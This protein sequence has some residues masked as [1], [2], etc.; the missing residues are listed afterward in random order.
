[1]DPIVIVGGAVAASAAGVGLRV[2]ARLIPIGLRARRDLREW[3]KSPEAQMQRRFA[4]LEK[5][6]RGLAN[7]KGRKRDSSIVGIYEDALRHV[8]GSYTRVYDVTL[9]ETMLSD[10]SVSDRRHDELARMFC[11]P[12]PPGTVMQYRYAV[13]PD[14]GRAIAEHLRT[15]NYGRTHMPASR[16]HDMNVDFYKALADANL[17]RREQA[18][19]SIRAPVKQACDETSKGLSAFTPEVVREIRRRGLTNFADAVSSSWARTADDGVVRR[20]VEDEQEA[21]EQAEK[22]FRTTEMQSPVSLR[23]L[24]R[25]QLWEVIYKGHV[26]NAR[27]VPKL[28]RMPGLDV[29][30]Y[31]CGE[32]V[33]DRGWYIM[34]GSYPV[35]IVSMFV[36]PEPEIYAD[37]MR[38]LTSHP[39]LTF[40]HTLVAEFIYLD[41]RKAKDQL[42]KRTKAVEVSNT[43]SEGR[44]R[45]DPEAN[46]ALRDLESVRNHIAGS[47]EALVQARFY[48]VVY[49][50]QARTRSEL[51]DSVK[52]LDT[53]C[54]QM[55]AAMQ[56]IDG[57]EAAR[58]EPAALHCLYPQTLV[59]EA[60]DQPTGREIM[61]VAHSLSTL[62]PIETA[63][64]GSA[65]PHTLLSTASGRLTALNLWDKSTRS[66]IKSPLVLILGEPGSGKTVT[67]GR[68]INDALG[69]VPD[70]QVSAI[71]IGGSLAPHADVVGARYL[72]LQP[73]DPRTINIWDSVELAEG[74]MPSDE[75]IALIVLDAMLLANVKPDDDI[76]SD[77]FTKAVT[78]VLKNFVPRN[79][80][81]RPKCE[82]THSHLVAMMESYDFG[83]TDLNA[84]AAKLALKLEKYVGNGWLDQPTH[85]DFCVDSPYDVYELD[86]LDAF[87]PDIRRTLANRIAARV[88]RTIGRPKDDGTR[89]PTM[90]AFIEVWKLIEYYPDMMRVIQ[91]GARTNRKENGVTILESHTYEDFNGIH[92]ITK[93]AGVKII[94]KQSG[95]F[96]KL[97]ED[98]GLS[99]RAVG[100]INAIKNI[101]GVHT[102]YVMVLGS[103]H[104]QQVEMIQ[105]DLSPTELWTF[106][107]NPDER[108]ARARVSALRPDWMLSDVVAWLAAEYPRGLAA[109]GLIEIDESL[110]A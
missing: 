15:R 30:D 78:Q 34:H 90:Q 11:V 88:I 49:G 87:P 104:D 73:D 23:R 31:L 52:N 83:H 93:T 54:E 27:S 19:L 33:E 1:M 89:T 66:N 77:L 65:R 95:D 4:Q 68:L 105:V 38:A 97:V 72:R 107:T 24:S 50:E 82:P 21:F 84:H 9:E 17:F 56:S 39:G 53:Y 7:P 47:S 58:E 100:A 79:G 12:K 36:P 96:S 55:V 110:L 8:D 60:D 59:G 92:D 69:T 91:K 26:L 75:Q 28:P 101:D 25:D 85:P 42:K 98:S 57:V 20:I 62:I 45:R 74:V 46:A 32:T 102:Q 10:D 63:W 43:D 99:E 80:P 64:R 6:Q 13:Y 40:R 41:K 48:A 35:S 76:A 61:E 103:G 16:L 2:G 70:L 109:Q 51:K 106:T 29:R 3:K 37:S 71:D 5:S 86:A 81:E 18:L 14:P 44:Q 67:A 94:G 108:N 22:V